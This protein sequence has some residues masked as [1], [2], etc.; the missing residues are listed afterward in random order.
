MKNFHSKSSPVVTNK[1]I[2]KKLLQWKIRREEM[3]PSE[4]GKLKGFY[5]IRKKNAVNFTCSVKDFKVYLL[6]IFNKLLCKK[7]VEN[8]W[9][10]IFTFLLASVITTPYTPFKFSRELFNSIFRDFF[11][12]GN[13]KRFIYSKSLISMKV[14]SCPLFFE[15]LNK[16]QALNLKQEKKEK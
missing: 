1:F 4:E 7:V 5:R 3:S 6:K 15:N 14:Y 12:H 8:A 2:H 10:F 11:R 13:K 9:L 16:E